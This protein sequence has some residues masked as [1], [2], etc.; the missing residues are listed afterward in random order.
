MLNFYQTCPHETCGQVLRQ[1]RT[2]I[3]RQM[4]RQIFRQIGRKTGKAVR[5][6]LRGF[7]LKILTKG[8]NMTHADQSEK[9]LSL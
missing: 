1:T 5:R 2:K 7:A 3:V 6:S 4:R 9:N 8:S